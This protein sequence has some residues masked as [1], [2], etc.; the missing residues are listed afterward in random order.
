MNT[1][2]AICMCLLKVS[3]WNTSVPH[4][5]IHTHLI[6]T[7]APNMLCVHSFMSDNRKQDSATTAAYILEIIDLLKKMKC[8]GAGIITI[9]ENSYV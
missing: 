1:M 6:H 8:L 7:V 4:T 2:V 9:W 5:N 3:F